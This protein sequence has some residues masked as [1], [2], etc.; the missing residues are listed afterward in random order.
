MGKLTGLTALVT[1]GNRGL[2]FAMALR[3][4]QDG[5][6]VVIVGRNADSVDMAAE[7]LRVHG[8]A[9]GVVADV[10]TEDGLRELFAKV[11]EFSPRLDILVNNAG[12]A[13]EAAFADVTRAGWDRVIGINLSA[14]FFVAQ[15]AATRMTA[16]GAIVNITSIDAYGADG[17]FSSYVAAKA[18]LV[19]LTKAA[20]VELAP[21]GI[22]VNAVSPGWTLTDM[23]AEATS[24]AM[25]AHMRSDF[26]RVPLRRLLTPDEI[27]SAVAYL[28]SPEAS[29]ITGVDLIV[30]GGTLANLYI[31]E[32][33]PQE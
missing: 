7:N 20:A 13:D 27:A 4:L 16:G 15:Q 11:D 31:L 17:P 8:R 6:D 9:R 33:L 10:S 18:G 12:V 26:G 24:V 14:P 2:G 21:Q 23:A 1:G 5:A 29:G 32:T 30:D 25:L 28:V 19:G 22:R 3:L